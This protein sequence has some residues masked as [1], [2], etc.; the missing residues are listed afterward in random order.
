MENINSNRSEKNSMKISLAEAKKRISRWLKVLSGIPEFK[1]KPNEIP[2]ALFIPL[3]DI[4]ELLADYEKAKS[5]KELVGIRVYF[6][7]KELMGAKEEPV[8]YE[9]DG[10]LVPVLYESKEKPHVDGI[11]QN[12]NTADPEKT[13]IYDFTAPCPRY[14]DK[15]S[16]LYL[17]VE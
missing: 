15:D 6:G 17:P 2:R 5:A 8:G 10:M 14:C 7:L 11:F 1:E 9:L 3:S 12:R 4:K 16:E 13:N